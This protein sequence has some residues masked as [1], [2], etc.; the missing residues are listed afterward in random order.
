M[1]VDNYGQQIG[2]EKASHH[3]FVNK[4]D[5][6]LLNSN[7]NVIFTSIKIYLIKK[8]LYMIDF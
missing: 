4:F 8:L 3:I 5:K 6:F 2:V 7:K 1:N